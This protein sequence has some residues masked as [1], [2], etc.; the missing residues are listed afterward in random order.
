MSKNIFATVL[1]LSFTVIFAFSANIASAQPPLALTATGETETTIF[2]S[3]TISYQSSVIPGY[4]II[5]GYELYMSSTGQEGPYI[6]VW[7]T[8]ISQQM[9]TYVNNLSP[10]ASY[11]FYVVATGL[12][13][14][15]YSDKVQVTMLPGATSIP[16][17]SLTP[18]STAPP[19]SNPPTYSPT[20]PS[21]TPPPKV[22]ETSPLAI[23][24]LFLS[25][26]YLVALI[27]QKKSKQNPAV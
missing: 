22:S 14:T 13:G 9:S 20:E 15:Y 1:T 12:S 7:N 16:I 27:R 17:S 23:L 8:M 25:A 10:D 19:I 24:P 6:K 4:E 21:T 2:L 3:W 11:F 26:L 18:N 5:A